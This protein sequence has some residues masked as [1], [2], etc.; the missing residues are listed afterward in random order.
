MRIF[1]LLLLGIGI[2]YMVLILINPKEEEL[3]PYFLKI[4]QI[5]LNHQTSIT[6]TNLAVEE[7]DSMQIETLKKDYGNIWAH[8]NQLYASNDVRLGKEYYTESWLK[9][10]VRGNN[11]PQNII[12]KRSD[13]NHELHIQNWATDALVCTLIDSNLVFRYDF[14]NGS[15]TYTKCNLAIVL[16]FQGDYW[17]IDA[18]R[19]LNENPI[20]DTN[21]ILL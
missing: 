12:L 8:L 20:L 1:L 10:H 9:Q 3:V 13:L 17:R 18:M 15:H 6:V 7:P 16:L 5:A 11:E 2:G 19:V 21:K 14:P 4:D